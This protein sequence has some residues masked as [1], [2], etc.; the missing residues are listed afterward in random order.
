MGVECGGSNVQMAINPADGAMCIIEM[1]PRVRWVGRGC[2]WRS[3]AAGIRGQALAVKA[4]STSALQLCHVTFCCAPCLP[5]CSR[6]S[7][8]ASKAT[9]FPI[10][11]IAAKLACGTT[12]DMIPNDITLKTPA[13]FEPSIDYVV[14]KIPRFAFEKFPGAQVWAALGACT[15]ALVAGRCPSPRLGIAS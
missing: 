3:D 13:S 9:G 4:A 6:S 11:K 8:L 7:A 14:T 12:L 10:A 5:H 1:N 15:F 2:W